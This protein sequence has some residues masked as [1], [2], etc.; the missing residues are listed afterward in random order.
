MRCDI[1]K[2]VHTQKG[3]IIMG[4]MWDYKLRK[5]EITWE[6]AQR[7]IPKAPTSMG[8]WEESR[9]LEKADGILKQAFDITASVFQDDKPSSGTRTSSAF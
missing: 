5:M 2:L 8:G 4:D 9:F 1:M 6:L 7:I 3:D